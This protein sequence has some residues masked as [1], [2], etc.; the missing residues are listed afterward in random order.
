MDRA[1]LENLLSQ[2]RGCTFANIDTNTPVSPGIHKETRGTRVL[3]YTNQ[4]GSAYEAMVRRR[5]QE[6][7][8]D[9]STFVSGDLPWG[10]QVPNS[11]L[12]EHKGK[13]YLKV[14]ELAPGKT[15]YFM[16]GQPVADPSGLD[17]KE[18]RSNNQGLAPSAQVKVSSYNI[19]N[20]TRIALMGE[21]LV[22][23][24]P[25]RSVLRINA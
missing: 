15:E 16:F 19:E 9:P 11:P 22:G 4:N 21:T 12:V 8:K 20:I 5:L 3:L 25:K 13:V 1:V 7:G 17:L 6:A 24:A 18:R 10:T 2:I 23:D 14:I